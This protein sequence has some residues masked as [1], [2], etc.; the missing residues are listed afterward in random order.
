MRASLNHTRG[1]L[2][3]IFLLAAIALTARGQETLKQIESRAV[4]LKSRGDAAGSLAAWRQAAALDP[5]SARIQDEIGF[6]LVVLNQREEAVGAFERAIELDSKFAPAHYHLGVLYW[7]R[8]DPNRGIPQLQTAVA[9]DG[10][11]S[12]YRYLLGHALNDTA[13]Y[14][15]ALTSKPIGARPIWIRPISTPAT[16]SVSCW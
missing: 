8:Q 9:L 3:F 10:D 7:L 4:E 11:N 1:S 16:I 5:K 15:E 13:N 6:L 12:D 2:C 14:R